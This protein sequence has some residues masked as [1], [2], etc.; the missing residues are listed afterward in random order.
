MA[1]EQV[2]GGAAVSFLLAQLGSH[3]T[4]RFAERLRPLGCTPP[5]VGILRML[6]DSPGVSQQ[7]LANAL[8]MHASRL[9]GV[10]DELEER[11]LIE[12]RPSEHDRRVYALHLTSKGGESFREIGQVA[13]DHNQAMMNGLTAEQQRQL[14]ELLELVA[15][16]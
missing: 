8:D 15:E 7:E 14:A 1:K 10:L 13:R 9:V 3:A 2:R 16:Q 6:A 5:Q 11:G 12:R 4:E